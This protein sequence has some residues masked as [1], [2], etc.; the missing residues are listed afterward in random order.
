MDRCPCDHELMNSDDAILFCHVAESLSFSRAAEQL[1]MSRSAVSKRIAQLERNLGTNLINRTPRSISLTEA[2]RIFLDHCRQIEQAIERAQEAVQDQ[3]RTPAGMLRF[4]IPTTLGAVLMPSMIQDF[5]VKY[6]DVELM[7]H[8]SEPFVDV[9][10]GAYDVVIRIARKL[11]DS[12]LVAQRLASTPRVLVAAP[13]Y[14]E[15][16]GTPSHVRDLKRHRC[17]GLS[18]APEGVIQWRFKGPQGPI[19]VPVTYAFT[20]NNDLALNLA[21]C[22]GLG[23]LYVPKIVV[24]GEIARNRLQVVLPEFCQGLDYGIYA[25]YPQKQPPA[26]VQVFVEFVSERLKVIH[27]SDLWSPL[28]DS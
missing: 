8:F 2:G 23:F 22:L 24:A 21:A 3:D 14:L 28:S 6:P 16:H 27:E 15:A 26:K 25:L 9:V 13:Q 11:T 7:T 5:L 17:L 10:G 1:G 18:F 20:A 4:S 19:D 12:S